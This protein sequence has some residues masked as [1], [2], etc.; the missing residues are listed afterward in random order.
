MNLTISA[1]KF[2]PAANS[3]VP[4]ITVIYNQAILAGGITAD[5]VPVTEASRLAFLKTI[6]IDQ[7]RPFW[8]A[9][10]EGKVV[11]YFYFRNFYDRPAYRITAEIGIYIDKYFHA[12]GLGKQILSYCI[13]IAPTI[14]IENILALIFGTNKG[15]IALFEK[16]GFEHAGSLKQLAKFD[17]HYQDLEIFVKRV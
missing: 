17:D 9:E 14:G 13:E 12:K 15:S 6:T 16:Y 4:A 1:I 3:D 7:N 10:S 11:G 2:R 8:V 5:T